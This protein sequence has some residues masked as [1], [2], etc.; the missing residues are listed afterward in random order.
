MQLTADSFVG[1]PNSLFGAWGK[2][3][4]NS[5][6][7]FNNTLVWI[8]GESVVTDVVLPKGVNFLC[9]G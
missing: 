7:L 9:E 1:L 3:S 8:G 2:L 5:F 4:T 6:Q